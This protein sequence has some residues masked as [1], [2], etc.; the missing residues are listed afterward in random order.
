M[1]RKART[2]PIEILILVALIRRLKPDHP[3]IQQL[4]VEL[5]KRK[6]GYRGELSINYYLELI[7]TPEFL[8]LHDIRLPDG[9]SFFQIDTLIITPH[10]ILILEVKN[11]AGTLY[12]EDESNQMIR[13]LNNEEEGMPNPIL[14]AKRHSRQL[15]YWLTQRKLP[16]LPIEF[17]VIISDPKTIIKA[18]RPSIFTKVMHSVNL[19]FTF[20]KIEKRHTK[21]T[22]TMKEMKKIAATIEKH[23]TPKRPDLLTQFAIQKDEIRNGV[24]CPDCLTLPIERKRGYWYCESCCKKSR[25]AFIQSLQ[26]YELLIKSTIT[27]EELRDF[28]Q[29]SSGKLAFQL[30]KSMNLDKVGENKGR[31]YHL[32]QFHYL[33]TTI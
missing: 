21:E 8:I 15:R 2:I 32:P 23:H 4:Q 22:L 3:K 30:L 11:M 26:D 17:L 6:K 19:P 7:D 16:I 1:I 9:K 13:T 5:A 33:H 14:Q 27:N 24:H 31:T 10:F 12:F 28:L 18:S 20:E 25:T 29:I